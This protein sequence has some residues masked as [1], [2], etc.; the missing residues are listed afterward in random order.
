MGFLKGILTIIVAYGLVQIDILS[1]VISVIKHGLLENPPLLPSEINWSEMTYESK[2]LNLISSSFAVLRNW[3]NK[4]NI[5]LDTRGAFADFLIRRISGNGRSF[6]VIGDISSSWL[7][8]PQTP[9]RPFNHVYNHAHCSGIGYWVSALLGFI[10]PVFF[11]FC[12]G[13]LG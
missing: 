7:S 4:C 1:G 10:G 8:H 5:Q 6:Q 13:G 3:F 2:R 9:S 11:F 12:V